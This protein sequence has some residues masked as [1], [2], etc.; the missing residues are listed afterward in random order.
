MKKYKGSIIL[1]VV[2]LLAIVLFPMC[3]ITTPENRYNVI[4]SFGE[5]VNVIDEPGLSFKAPWHNAKS[6]PSN[7][8]IY[9]L[10]PSNVI[11]SDKKTMEVDSYVLWTIEDP[12]LFTESLNSSIMNAESRI[13][14]TI[15]NATKNVIGTMSQEELIAARGSVLEERIVEETNN[16]LSSQYGI[17]LETVNIKRLDFP[18]GNKEAV[19]DR[20]ISERNNI[21]ATFL[22]EG[23]SE[24]QIIKNTA[25]AEK[26]VIISEAEKQAAEIRGDADAQYIN[27]TNSVYDTP[28]EAEFYTFVL[29]LEA[30]EASLVGDNKTIILDKDSPLVD[31]LNGQ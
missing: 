30:L 18:E 27:I 15:Y 24:A 12:V 9:D 14:T 28:L 16:T 3:T 22:A 26:A 23:Q 20:M 31:I 4:Y 7:I 21:S 1:A 5:I 13:N 10:A 11:T 29:G 19:Y 2:I 6:L 25:D 8:S 17:A